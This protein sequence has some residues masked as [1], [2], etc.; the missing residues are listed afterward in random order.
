MIR[1]TY[2]AL[3]LFLFFI[4]CQNKPNVYVENTLHKNNGEIK[5][6]KINHVQ[7]E[8]EATIEYEPIITPE[9]STSSSL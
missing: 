9:E 3:P 4:G 6:D 1:K 8:K 7:V 5:A 2:L